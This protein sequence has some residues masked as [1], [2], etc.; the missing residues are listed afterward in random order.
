MKDLCIDLFVA[1]NL[2]RMNER[3]VRAL[4]L[5]PADPKFI[6][7]WRDYENRYERVVSDVW[8]SDL[9]PELSGAAAGKA[10]RA[11]L[12]WDNADEEASE[13]AGSIEKAIEFARSNADQDHRWDELQSKFVERVQ[14]GLAAWDWLKQDA[15]FDLRG[16]F[17]RRAIVPFVLVPRRIAAKHSSAEK[18]SLLK[19]LEQAHDAF[20]F[21]APY[22][23]LAL[24]RSV[25]EAVLRDHYRAEGRDLSESIRNA[26]GRLPRH[27][28]EAALH[29]LR[30]LA[31]AVLHL[32]GED[33]QGLRRM[34]EVRLE[35][36]IVSLLFVV[37]ALVEDV[38]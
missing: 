7:A 15:G 38:R 3:R 27:A 34:D 11:D 24:M 37:R 12:E 8:L 25:V 1:A 35:K 31:N 20:V 17:R 30:K 10:G 16:V 13:Q 23:A 5:A 9:L 4:L 18:L 26:R 22:A 14:D 2:L 28:N 29:R 36:E 19:N 33:D 6:A 21:G 32:D